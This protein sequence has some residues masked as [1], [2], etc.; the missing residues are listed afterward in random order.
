MNNVY[1]FKN[2]EGL[3]FQFEGVSQKEFVAD[4][5]M[6]FDLVSMMS[7]VYPTTMNVTNKMYE[8]RIRFVKKELGKM[9]LTIKVVDLNKPGKTNGTL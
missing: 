4:I 6:A 8:E 3:K 2:I 1:T 7:G 9:G 5:R